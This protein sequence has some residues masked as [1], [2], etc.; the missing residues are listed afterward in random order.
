MAGGIARAARADNPCLTQR[1]AGD[2]AVILWDDAALQAVRTTKPGP[3][4]VS[5]AI[6]VVH[7]SMFDAWAAYDATAVPT[8]MR[9]GWRQP[10]AE[11][12]DANK[13]QAV[14]FAA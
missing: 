7:T 4:V 3:T 13:A 10:A 12:T 9:R 8:V 5:R 11:R 6:A 14:S 2:N 1:V